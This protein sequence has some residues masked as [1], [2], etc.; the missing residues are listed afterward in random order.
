MGMD[1]ELS[2]GRAGKKSRIYEVLDKMQNTMVIP[3][4]AWIAVAQSTTT[5]RAGH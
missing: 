4:R 2:Q 5:P 1:D 3:Q